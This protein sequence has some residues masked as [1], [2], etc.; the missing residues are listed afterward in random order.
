MGQ[1]RFT[2]YAQSVSSIMEQQMARTGHADTDSAAALS[3]F[4]GMTFRGSEHGLGMGGASFI[5]RLSAGFDRPAVQ[6]TMLRA[7]GYGQG[8]GPSYVDAMQQI[9]SGATDKQNIMTLY[10]YLRSDGVGGDGMKVVMGQAFGLKM[11]EAS[12]LVDALS[13]PGVRAYMSGDAD[14]EGAVKEYM[15][16]LKPNQR[17]ALA[18]SGLPGLGRLAISAGEGFATQKE[19]LVMKFGPQMAALQMDILEA[20]SNVAQTI[21]NLLGEDFAKAIQ[22]ATEQ[23]VI[24]TGKLE[25]WSRNKDLDGITTDAARVT[26]GR[27]LYDMQMGPTRVGAP[28]IYLPGPS[29]IEGR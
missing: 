10:D 1:G 5:Q 6:S 23:V 29:R 27:G 24:F 14:K 8:D 3:M 16:G 22:D 11:F 21:K 15:K 20:S 4:A 18:D 28:G 9:E 12:E 19:A 17:A 2:E 13:N 7:L 26:G 25:E